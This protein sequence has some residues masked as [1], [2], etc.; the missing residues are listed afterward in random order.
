M[1]PRCALTAD[2]Q[3]LVHYHPHCKNLIRPIAV[4][5]LSTA[6]VMFTAAL[7]NTTGWTPPITTALY[8]TLGVIWF[9]FIASWTLRPLCRWITTHF[10]ITD[11]RIMVRQILFT[12]LLSGVFARA[13]I[14]IVLARITHVTMHQRLTER[15][16]RS[17]T[18]IIESTAQDPLEIP[19]IPRIKHL[20]R[21][22]SHELFGPPNTPGADHTTND[23]AVQHSEELRYF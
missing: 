15:L 10:V 19:D 17:G 6:V 5:L 12:G 16:L 1:F 4:L 23:A 2:E 21:L 13:G 11:R 22:L 20:H 8:V 9:F 7:I 18:L 3:L 14:D